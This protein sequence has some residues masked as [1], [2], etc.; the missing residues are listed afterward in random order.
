M[1]MPEGVKK[2][3]RNYEQALR[4][5]PEFASSIEALQKLKEK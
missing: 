3:I 2:A 1:P 5:D 4:L